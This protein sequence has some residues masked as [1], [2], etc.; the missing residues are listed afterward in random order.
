MGIPHDD[1]LAM[2]ESVLRL[3]L[4]VIEFSVLKILERVFSFHRKLFGFEILRTEEKVFGFNEYVVDRDVINRPTKLRRNYINILHLD[5]FA[6]TQGFD[7][8]HLGVSDIDIVAVP[9]GRS[10]LIGHLNVF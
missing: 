5:V 2:P 1:V 7:A 9:D 8:V 6:F 4:T 3:E 10:A